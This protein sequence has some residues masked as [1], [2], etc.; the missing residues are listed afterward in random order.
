[1]TAA[2]PYIA[3]VDEGNYLHPVVAMLR[4]GGWDP[5]HYLYPQLPGTLVAAGL[6]LYAPVFRA[7]HGGE[8]RDALVSAPDVY[9]RLE[10]FAVLAIARAI[11]ALLGVGTVVL[12]GLL[13]RRLAGPVAGAAAAWLA[14]FAPA[15]VLRSAL[16]SVDTA[17]AFF[18]T[19]C[20]LLTERA[21]RPGPSGLSPLLAGAAA[22]AAFASKYPAASVG[23][24]AAAAILLS[25]NPRV[26]RLRRVSLLAAGA[27]A[28][29]AAAM[30][31][32]LLR[33]HE[34]IGALAVQRGLYAAMPSQAPLWKQALVR[35]EWTLPFEHPELGVVFVA[36]AI[37]GL[38]ALARRRETAAAAW[39][40]TLWAALMIGFYGSRS[41]QPFR[42]A[43]PF[44]PAACAA[45]G[46]GYALW[47]ER[48]KRPRWMDAAALA[49]LLAIWGAP[50]ARYTSTRVRLADSRRR[51]VDWLAGRASA[52]SRTLAVRDL[53]ILSSELGR[54]PGATD[55]RWWTE[56]ENA[57]RDLRPQWILAGVQM[58]ASGPPDD[59]AR[60]PWIAAGY[61][62]RARFGA[63][64]TPPY[65][66][67]WRGNDQLV[68]V[69]ERR[70]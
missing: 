23:A 25:A 62:E 70:R 67:W 54:V 20:L 64:S 3:Y 57:A 1:M 45:A 63:R 9:D 68:Y 8:L 47:R 44:V 65:V 53:G 37:A 4:R 49:L 35:A 26:E 21:R 7:R 2:R 10:P 46:A 18:A 39:G 50:L 36:A 24:A 66:S 19:L 29:V 56:S 34:V 22:G 31:A 48:L 59:A 52:G 55:V 11:D 28:A 12:A 61:T 33:P 27:V 58:R 17:A 41:F 38:V 69:F 43:L 51:A 16:A 5:H 15:L 14:A 60:A 32:A 6:R 40:W 13:A 30:P 42:N